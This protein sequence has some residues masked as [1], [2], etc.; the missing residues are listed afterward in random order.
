MVK[1]RP[2]SQ[3]VKVFFTLMRSRV[4]HAQAVGF[5]FGTHDSVNQVLEDFV[6]SPISIA[7]IL[8]W[9]TEESYKSSL[10]IVSLI[11]KHNPGF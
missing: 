6:L 1:I 2:S 11:S 9:R 8:A 7:I 10:I 5:I 3:D 4:N